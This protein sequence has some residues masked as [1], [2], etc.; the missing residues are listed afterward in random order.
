[1]E[2][3]Y[4]G[5]KSDIDRNVSPLDAGFERDSSISTREISVGRAALLHRVTAA[6]SGAS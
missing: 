2:K 3:G 5:W 4:R 1:M 6:R